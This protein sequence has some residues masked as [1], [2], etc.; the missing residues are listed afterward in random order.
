MLLFKSP[1]SG[2]YSVTAGGRVY[3]VRDGVFLAEDDISPEV[4]AGFEAADHVRDDL[5]AE[6]KQLGSHE[7]EKV[8]DAPAGDAA[9]AATAA[10]KVN[11]KPLHDKIDSAHAR[12]DALE[13]QV[14]GTLA[15]IAGKVSGSTDESDDA[16]IGE[17]G[18]A[19]SL[20]E[21]IAA[22]SSHD[23]ANALASEIGV[24]GFQDKKPSVDAKKEALSAKAAEIASEPNSLGAQA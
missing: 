21:R 8:A 9:V 23:E 16:T 14:L 20:A 19:P 12:I 10:A 7:A 5:V 24:E 15:E 4:A 18:A 17:V 1:D 11:L 22:V 13:G 6:L 2:A 3:P